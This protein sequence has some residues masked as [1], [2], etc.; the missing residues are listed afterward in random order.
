MMVIEL[1][2]SHNGKCMNKFLLIIGIG[3]GVGAGLGLWYFYDQQIETAG[4]GQ[5]IARIA[6]VAND[7]KY[8]HKNS[9]F[10]NKALVGTSLYEQS[11]ILT[12]DGST[13]RVDMMNSARLEVPERT[14]IRIGLDKGSGGNSLFLDVQEGKVQIFA[15]EAP[16]GRMILSSA[17]G[18]IELKIAAHSTLLI[19]EKNSGGAGASISVM[20]GSVVLT[21]RGES[22]RLGPSESIS[23]SEGSGEANA[24]AGPFF[25]AKEK[26]LLTPEMPNGD[27]TIYKSQRVLFKWRAQS[28]QNLN[29]QIS[30]DPEFSRIFKSFDVSLFKEIFIGTEEFERGRYYWRLVKNDASNQ[31]FSSGLTF[32]IQTP[33]KTVLSKVRKLF[34]GR[35]EWSLEVAV[36]RAPSHKVYHFQIS[37]DAEFNSIFDEYEGHSPMRS[38]IDKDGAFYVRARERLGDSEYGQWSEHQQEQIR[39]P[40]ESPLL[41]SVS[42]RFDKTSGY[43]TTDLKWSKADNASAY[44]IQIS[45]DSKFQS[46]R[47]VY[48][49]NQNQYSFKMADA[50]PGYFRVLSIS[51]EGEVS[52][53][54]KI[55]NINGVLPAAVIAKKVANGPVLDEA[56]SKP[57][58]HIQWVHNPMFSKY[59]VEI[60]KREDL[61][62]ADRIETENIE[63]KYS[64]ADEGWYYIRI[65]GI[66]K[67]LEY[68]VVSGAVHAIR[69]V[70]PGPLL[71]TQKFYPKE[72]EVFILPAK[73]QASIP[74]SWQEIPEAEWYVV[75]LAKFDDFRSV[76]TYRS[77]RSEFVLKERLPSGRW[78]FRIKARNPYQ[79]S[80]WSSTGVFYIG[81]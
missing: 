3:F 67:Q 22:H 24:G 17:N 62:S 10:Y 49:S 35:G 23:V 78:Y 48:Q 27:S 18:P 70:K 9:F 76:K 32:H 40:I 61:V 16:V 19:G 51:K 42:Q 38:F 30:R 36:F 68:S 11:E 52:T 13:S 33:E 77:S 72:N 37:K 12:G 66:P 25:K 55:H 29:I 58:I 63:L 47:K 54:A 79:E 4:E 69:Y 7:V 60:S 6:G 28:S 57:Q 73:I 45:G 8:K 56:S 44:I 81:S 14:L 65:N 21:G 20:E 74:F 2:I 26:V 71:P 80:V 59:I 34:V 1:Y 53:G 50:E 43:I 46:V 64:I 31:Y 15:G 75:E 5:V 41:Q 39:P